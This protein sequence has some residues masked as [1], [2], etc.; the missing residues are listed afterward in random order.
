MGLTLFIKYPYSNNYVLQIK[1]CFNFSEVDADTVNLNL[2]T[3]FP[4]EGE[5]A[6]FSSKL[7]LHDH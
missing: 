5:G 3:L 7:W 1:F 6:V 4:Q 2:V